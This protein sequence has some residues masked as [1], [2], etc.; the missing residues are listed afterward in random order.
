MLAGIDIGGTKIGLCL[1]EADGTVLASDRFETPRDT[2]PDLVLDECLTRLERLA[3]ERVGVEASGGEP[4]WSALGVSCPGPF[5]APEGRFLTPPNMP[6]WHGFGLRDALV[7]RCT[8]ETDSKIDR[9]IDCKVACKNDA[10]ALALAEYLW[11][12][13]APRDG[14]R[15]VESL[16]YLTMSTGMGAGLVL[17]G[18]LY[19]GRRGFAGEIGHLRLSDEG[20][21]GFGKR[22]SCEGFL[23]GP[24]IAQD[25]LAERLRCEQLGE[26]TQL[27]QSDTQPELVFRAASEGD[28][29][30]RRVVDRVAR[31]LGQVIAILVDVLE[32]EVFVLGT[33]GAAWI[34]ELEAGT[35]SVLEREALAISLEGVRIE[36]SALDAPGLQSAL[37]TALQIDG[38]TREADDDARSSIPGSH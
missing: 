8:S 14:A 12:A 34:D 35:R 5:L 25:A 37:A 33:I 13:G 22:G 23:S 30:A 24:G 1:G 26:A 32:I 17:G 21:V 2:A 31:R 11:G 4:A 10:N 7:E 15:R 20:P 28:P 16:C 27:L 19:E 18:R 9:K 38:S 36:A 6:A 3:R 29:A